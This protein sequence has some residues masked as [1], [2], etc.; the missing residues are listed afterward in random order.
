MST[1]EMNEPVLPLTAQPGEHAGRCLDER[2]PQ[3]TDSEHPNHPSKQPDIQGKC[4]LIC[5]VY[6]RVVGYLTRTKD[7]NLGKKEEFSE[8]RTF[9]EEKALRDVRQEQTACAEVG[10]D[11][12]EPDTE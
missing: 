4:A 11:Y 3:C 2:C 5:D 1:L 10:E 8:R 9:D 7:W 12:R 6:S